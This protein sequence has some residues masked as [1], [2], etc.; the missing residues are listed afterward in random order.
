MTLTHILILLGAAA[1]YVALLPERLRRWALFVGSIAA[2]Y[3]LQPALRIQNLDFI[4]PTATL[5]LVALGWLLSRAPDQRWTRED[6]VS[7]AL[8]AAL[9]LLF[10]AGRYLVEAV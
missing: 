3:W 9:V 6:S 8:M 10:S 5:A 7:A 2:I 4:F 1:L